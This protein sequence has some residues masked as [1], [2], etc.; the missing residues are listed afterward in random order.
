MSETSVS[1]P[2]EDR[3]ELSQIIA[4]NVLEEEPSEKF[5]DALI[6]EDPELMEEGVKWGFHDT[7]VREDVARL[8]SKFLINR[9]WPIYGDRLTREEFSKFEEDLKNAYTEWLAANRN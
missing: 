9:T 2:E 5:L 6:E 7:V 3:L 1:L 8:C 4:E